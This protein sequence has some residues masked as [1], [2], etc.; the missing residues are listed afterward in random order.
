MRTPGMPGS[1]IRM[2][3]DLK[4]GRRRPTNGTIAS[5]LYNVRRFIYTP[6]QGVVVSSSS[7]VPWRQWTLPCLSRRCPFS[8][9]CNRSF[10]TVKA[11]AVPIAK[12]LPN[13]VR[14]FMVSFP[15]GVY[16]GLRSWRSTILARSSSLS[17]CRCA[18]SASNAPSSGAIGPSRPNS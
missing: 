15:F 12:I 6:Q 18:T 4:R 2:S 8:S 9:L 17:M 7:R 13:S 14:L 1:K 11:G 16:D 5:S 10:L 3:V